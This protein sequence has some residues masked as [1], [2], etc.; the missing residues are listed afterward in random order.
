MEALLKRMGHEE[1]P[2]K[3]LRYAATGKR[4]CAVARVCLTPGEGKVVVNGRPYEAFFP[5]STWQ[6]LVLQPFD[7][8]ETRGKYDV[9]V[10]V[11]GGGLSGQAGAVR[12]GIT[13]SLLAISPA[14]RSV[15]KKMGLITRDPRVKERKKYGQKGARKRFQYSKR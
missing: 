2:V 3:A 7:L 4:K 8:T 5:R 11:A 12:H 6:L 14:F 15:L 9:I 10:N 1:E 13:K